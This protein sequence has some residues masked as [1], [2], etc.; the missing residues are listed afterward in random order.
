MK[1]ERISLLIKSIIWGTVWLG[2]AA[3]I[4]LIITK[5]TSYKDFE[6]VLF[7]EGLI[8]IFVGIFASIS[9]DPMGLSLQGL[10]QSNAQYI[11]NANLEVS[12]MSREKVSGKIDIRFALSTLSLVI[13]GILSAAITFII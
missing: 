11:A 4:A 3:L 5:V 2:L 8:L 12:K 9:G 1:D 10:G 13:G 6:N 7:I